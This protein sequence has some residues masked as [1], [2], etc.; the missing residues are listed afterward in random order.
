MLLPKE[1]SGKNTDFSQIM[2]NQMVYF[3]PIFTVIILIGLP[4]ALGLYWTASGLFSII[5]QYI[6]LRKNDNNGTTGIKQN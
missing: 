4:S 1:K 2:Q 6:I 3:M 5:Q